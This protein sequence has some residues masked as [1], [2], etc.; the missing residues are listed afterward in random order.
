V[1]LDMGLGRFRASDSLIKRRDR[2]H[3]WA[4]IPAAIAHWAESRRPSSPDFLEANA[5]LTRTCNDTVVTGK[6]GIMEE[7]G[8]LKECSSER[9]KHPTL[10]SGYDGSNPAAYFGRRSRVVWLNG[11]PATMRLS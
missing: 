3:A 4:E 10:L 2:H 9:L 1:G 7:K 5:T 6:E 8:S 11:G